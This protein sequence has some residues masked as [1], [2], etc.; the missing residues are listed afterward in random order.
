MLKSSSIGSMRPRVVRS[1]SRF[2]CAA[3]GRIGGE[4]MTM[5]ERCGFWLS[6]SDPDAPRG[7]RFLGVAIVDMDTEASAV[8]IIRHTW[9]L[10]IN[11]GGAVAITQLDDRSALR[12]AREH[13]NKLITDEA[14][15]IRLGS[16]GRKNFDA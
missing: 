1:R 2:C 4:P 15:L 16:R 11:P 6:F 8:E 12:I 5:K 7:K 13:R 14:Q 3:G 9:K 10:G